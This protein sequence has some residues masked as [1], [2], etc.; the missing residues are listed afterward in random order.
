MTT[1][2]NVANAAED[3]AKKQAG[4]FLKN[5]PKATKQEIFQRAFLAGMT[6]GI[7]MLT[8]AKEELK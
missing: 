4:I 6:T 7:K 1:L 5:N 2:E 3:L 8:Y